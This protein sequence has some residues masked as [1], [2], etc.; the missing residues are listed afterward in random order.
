M[1]H[2]LYGKQG[3]QGGGQGLRGRRKQ[4][5]QGRDRGL[6]GSALKYIAAFSMLLDHVGLVLLEYLLV[7]GGHILAFDSPYR[8]MV[9]LWDR[10]LRMA[11]RLAFPI[12]CLLL[13][14]G[15]V[16]TR[17]RGRYLLRL[18]VFALIS[19]IPFDLAV[20]NQWVCWDGQNVMLELALGLMT[21]WAAEEAARRSVWG[22][23]PFAFGC[24]VLVGSLAAE[25]LRADY[26]AVGILY[27][28]AFFWLR[29]N[30]AGRG[31]AAG[32]LGLLST[33]EVN[34]GAG[35]LSGIFVYLYNGRRGRAGWRYGFYLFYPAH[36]LALFLIRRL[37]M[38]I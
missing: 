29:E 2:T 22:R 4:A 30:R 14:E 35:A 10:G 23:N 28:A 20:Y 34:K 15:F 6:S 13:A 3:P 31:A 17:S 16:H 7:Y 27:M 36:L 25:A 19:E 12:F 37:G 8:P 1:R 33:L 21:L 24:I 18:G 11:G 5:E 26:G 32:L 9:V 38:G